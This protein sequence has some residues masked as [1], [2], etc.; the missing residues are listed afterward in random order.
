MVMGNICVLCLRYTCPILV[1][2]VTWLS[3][4]TTQSLL[5]RNN[6][7]NDWILS[8][9]I[10]ASLFVM[11]CGA[12][13]PSPTS[14]IDDLTERTSIIDSQTIPDNRSSIFHMSSMA[15]YCL[16]FSHLSIP[17]HGPHSC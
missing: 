6:Y 12:P 1:H 9:I 2:H 17:L 7:D 16:N 10:H 15:T 14:V 3:N 5:I 8:P 4:A 13:P 11:G